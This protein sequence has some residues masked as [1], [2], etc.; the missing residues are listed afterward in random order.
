MGQQ[1]GGSVDATE[2]MEEARV[3]EMDLGGLDEAFAQVG[4]QR[5]SRR[6]M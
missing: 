6:I 3:A 1:A 2:G 4:C 5:S